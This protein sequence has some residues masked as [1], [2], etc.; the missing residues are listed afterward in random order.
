[1]PEGREVSFAD[2]LSHVSRIRG[3][4]SRGPLRGLEVEREEL[5]AHVTRAVE[6]EMPEEALAG[7]EA[8][9][10][11]LGLVGPGFNYRQTMLDL[12]SSKLAGLYDPHLKA[13]LIRSGLGPADRQMTLL[14]ELVHALQDQHY[15]VM[16]VVEWTP[17]DTDRSGALSA[18]AEGD[19]TSAMFDGMMKDGKTALS[20]PPGFIQER[21]RADGDL[22]AGVPS[23][24]HRSLTASYIDG[25]TF[26]HELRARGG[27]PAVDEAWKRPPITTEQILHLDKYDTNEGPLVVPVPKAPS[28][29]FELVLHDTWGEQNLRL[30]FEEWLDLENATAAAT[31]WGGDRI[32]AYRSSSQ[33]ITVWHLVADDEAAARRYFSALSQG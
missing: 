31:G 14:H 23:I 28:D 7:T 22:P 2:E 4:S 16:E 21:M 19:A 9:L 1:M 8:M 5:L 27:F 12:L 11:G 10:L 29:E 26:V 18:L 30:I 13:M 15:D 33:T 25:L 6:L 24:I 20:L 3:L 17:D 32:V